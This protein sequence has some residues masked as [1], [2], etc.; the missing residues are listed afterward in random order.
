MKTCALIYLSIFLWALGVLPVLANGVDVRNSVVKVYVVKSEADYFSPWDSYFPGQSTGSGFVIEGHRILTNAHVV[1]DQTFLQVRLNG[2][3]EKHVARVLFVSHEADLALLTVKTASFFEGITPLRFRELPALGQDVVIYGFPGGEETL[4]ATRGTVTAIEEQTY[5]HSDTALQTVK[6]NGAIRKGN[7][8]APAMVDGQVVGVAMQSQ[9][10][11]DLGH[12]VP[13]PIVRQF[14]TDV[15]DG[16][17]EGIPSLGI[18]WQPLKNDGLRKMCGLEANQSGVLIASVVP[19]MPADGQLR[20]RD[21]VLTMNDRP[22][23]DD[24]TIE[25]RGGERAPLNHFVRLHQMGDVIRVGILRDGE[26]LQV[27]VTLDQPM[28]HQRLVPAGHD[29]PPA[30]YVYGGLVF[31]GLTLNHLKAWGKQWNDDAPERLLALR[32]EYRSS[33]KEQ[34]VV[35]DHV[36]PSDVN[37]GYH[38]VGDRRII[39]VDDQKVHNLGQLVQLVEAGADRPFVVFKDD[40]DGLIV[41]DRQQV[42]LE[43]ENILKDYG[44][45]ADRSEGLR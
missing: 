37:V 19:G 18:R 4:S 34:V 41:L 17:F 23:D 9:M 28:N 40:Q 31:S 29:A 45:P 3:D 12:I 26:R 39:E 42:Q 5:V 1:A 22:L 43:N 32:H 21:V 24:G 13:M 10:N 16:R 6:L 8:G 35:L 20:E 36:L 14:L 7:S 2:R 38:T 25:M 33:E 27:S 11:G 44:V 30:Y 15:E